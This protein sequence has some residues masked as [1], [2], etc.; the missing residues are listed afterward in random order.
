M[1]MSSAILNALNTKR[2]HGREL[3]ELQQDIQYLESANKKL[4]YDLDAQLN[5]SERLQYDCTS[6]A[7]SRQREKEQ[8]QHAQ[9]LQSLQK[10]CET[11]MTIAYLICRIRFGNRGCADIFAE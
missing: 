11:T 2:R 10:Q 9:A 7:K 3:D 5:S 1:T 8:N 6:Y 4:Q